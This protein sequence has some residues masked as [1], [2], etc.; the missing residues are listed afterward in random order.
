M[1]FREWFIR[2]NLHIFSFM[3]IRFS[4]Q[5]LENVQKKKI[6][7]SRMQIQSRGLK[8]LYINFETH[9]ENFYQKNI[10]LKHSD[11]LIKFIYRTFKFFHIKLNLMQVENIQTYAEALAYMNQLTGS[12]KSM[13]YALEL[14]GFYLPEFSS[15]AITA[16]Y[17]WKVLN[18]KCF[19]IIKDDVNQGTLLKHA[20]KISL[21]DE[22]SKLVKVDMAIDEK[23]MPD[24]RW[25]INILFS[26]KSDHTLFRKPFEDSQMLVT[27]EQ[28]LLLR[29]L[30]TSLFRGKGRNSFFKRTPKQVADKKHAILNQRIIKQQAKV[31]RKQKEQKQA[32]NSLLK[33]QLRQ[34]NLKRTEELMGK[35]MKL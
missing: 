32:Q 12:I 4:S 9:H 34:E 23:N 15:S 30:D 19:N 20:T 13:W 5:R 11:H 17:L 1:I 10:L 8:L 22:I 24:K 18:N 3:P 21:L 28:I 31:I 33:A 29:E 25:L 6:S 2:Q 14:K 35:E 16:Q 7:Y 26:I 27:K